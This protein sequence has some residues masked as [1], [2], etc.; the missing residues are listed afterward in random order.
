M[1]LLLV[2]AS[3]NFLWYNDYIFNKIIIPHGIFG[4]VI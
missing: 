3:W 2:I 1:F 4:G